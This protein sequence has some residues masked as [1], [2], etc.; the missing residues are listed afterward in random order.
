[1]GL[2]SQSHNVIMLTSTGHIIIL[3]ISEQRKSSRSVRANGAIPTVWVWRV[4]TDISAPSVPEKDALQ[5]FC[6]TLSTTAGS[7]SVGPA[8]N[9]GSGPLKRQPSILTGRDRVVTLVD[10]CY[11]KGAGPEFRNH[12]LSLPGKNDENCLE[13]Q[14]YFMSFVVSDTGSLLIYDW[15][16]ILSTDYTLRAQGEACGSLL[17]HR[18]CGQLGMNMSVGTVS[19]SCYKEV[20]RESPS[21]KVAKGK[22]ILTKAS[23]SLHT[24]RPVT[25]SGAVDENVSVNK[26]VN[27]APGETEKHCRTPNSTVAERSRDRNKD[28]QGASRSNASKKKHHM[29]DVVVSDKDDGEGMSPYRSSSLYDLSMSSAHIEGG[30]RMSRAKLS[31]FLEK[32]GKYPDEYRPMIWRFLLKLPENGMAFADLVNRG[33]HP[34]FESR[35]LNRKYP[36]ESSRLF[37]KLQSLCSQLSH[38]SS[39]FSE[40]PYIP[41]LCFPFILVFDNDELAALESVMS[42]LMWWGYAWH[43]CHPN[44][45]A[46]LCD[47]FDA[48]LLHFD[49]NLHR[50]FRSLEISPGLIGWRL[51][52]TLYSEFLPKETWLRL[53]DFIFT[54]FECMEIMLLVPVVIMRLC[55]PSLLCVHSAEHILRFFALQQDIKA[56]S[57]ISMVEHM[58]VKTPKNLFV[59][60]YRGVKSKAHD[61]FVSVSSEVLKNSSSVKNNKLKDTG[62]PGS[63]NRPSSASKSLRGGD[64]DA[65]IAAW[66]ATPVESIRQSLSAEAGSPVFPLPRGK[67]PAYDGYPKSVVDWELRKRSVQV[68]LDEELECREDVLKELEKRITEVSDGTDVRLSLFTS[69]LY[70]CSWKVTTRFG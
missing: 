12:L 70:F 28:R 51:T 2:S 55:N 56:S 8:K 4:V 69:K 39:I 67:Y 59:A 38:W 46:Q 62:L 35:S 11:R 64:L 34:A 27:T 44:P 36:L 57:I 19:P 68:T 14:T 52:Y 41:Q 32:N 16:S 40:A 43:I 17:R 60:C 54:N 1:M 61:T 30:S 48:I 5:T 31:F 65:E 6:P 42:I 26:K 49:P 58:I 29:S 45:P 37:K 9:K 15:S 33:T 66:R 18:G 20:S 13:Q 53:M 23:S 24:S 25:A 22:G 63:G 10:A 3:N 50:H 21:G 7:S 47:S